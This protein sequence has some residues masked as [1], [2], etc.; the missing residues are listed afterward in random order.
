MEADGHIWRNFFYGTH[1]FGHLRRHTNADAI[2]KTKLNRFFFQ[3]SLDDI[4][5]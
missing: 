3:H 2:C 1:H 4:E 5:H